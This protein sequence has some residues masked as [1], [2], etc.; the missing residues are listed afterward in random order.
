MRDHLLIKFG[1]L[2]EAK[3]QKPSELLALGIKKQNCEKV[4]SDI[5]YE[6]LLQINNDVA[7]YLLMK[8]AKRLKVGIKEV[9]VSKITE[10]SVPDNVS[11]GKN[12]IKHVSR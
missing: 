8:E 12:W 2:S 10:F 3:I 1:N 4:A 5:R 7:T 6:K 9:V 11:K